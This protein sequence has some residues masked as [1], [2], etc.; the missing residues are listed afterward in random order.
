MEIRNLTPVSI[1]Q[2]G[3]GAFE[4]NNLAIAGWEN[5]LVSIPQSGFGAFEPACMP[6]WTG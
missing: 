1:P 3:F 2:S 6:T 5:V 4:L